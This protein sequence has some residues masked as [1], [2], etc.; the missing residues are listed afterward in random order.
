MEA[1]TNLYKPLMQAITWLN[2]K[3][4]PDPSHKDQLQSTDFKSS[5][6]KQ[7]ITKKY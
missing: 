6:I 2:K 3:D 7:R 5:K 1:L 4:K